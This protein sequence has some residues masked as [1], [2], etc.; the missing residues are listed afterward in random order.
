MPN[1]EF[2]AEYSQPLNGSIVPS[3]A[4]LTYNR[5]GIRIVV[6]QT[7]RIGVFDIQIFLVNMV[8]AL[9]LIVLANTI[10]DFIAIYLCP[11][12][13]LYSQYA[14]R[15]TVSLSDILDVLPP[16]KINEMLR[17]FR[18]DEHLVD[19]V[20]PGILKWQAVAAE[21]ATERASL[22]AAFKPG[23]SQASDRR[24]R[25]KQAAS[26]P[27][28]AAAASAGSGGSDA[29]ADGGEAAGARLLPP[30]PTAVGAAGGLAAKTDAPKVVGTRNPLSALTA[31]APGPA[32]LPPPPVGGA[33]AR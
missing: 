10:V 6:S 13:A 2:K 4:R 29:P 19:P 16:H 25:V 3:P 31:A 21:I 23:A 9:G 7:G 26:P 5:H 22:A 8:V 17:E 11:L 30:T 14:Q 18:E 12:R 24:L 1:S 32:L 33:G 27:A 15:V 20:P 28:E